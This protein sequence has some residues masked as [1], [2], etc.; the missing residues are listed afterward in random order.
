[1]G[2]SFILLHV[3]IQFSKH[4]LLKRLP[5]SIV[6]APLSNQLAAEGGFVTGFSVLFHCLVLCQDGSVVSHIRY[7]D[8]SSLL[9]AHCFGNLRSF[10]LPSEL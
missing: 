1:M 10:V 5:F 9:S 4:H 2:S 6:L 8:A 3:A 7:C